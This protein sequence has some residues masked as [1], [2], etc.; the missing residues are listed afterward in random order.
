MFD[1]S[2]LLDHQ[3][4]LNVN[5]ES[6]PVILKKAFEGNNV[7]YT[8]SKQ[9]IILK[10]K[11][12]LSQKKT[13][14]QRVIS[15]VVTDNL[16]EPVIGANVI[17][18]GTTVGLITDLDGRFEIKTD[19]K[20]PVLVFSF[21]G[22]KKQRVVV[23]NRKRL[24]V[25]MKT[26]A[27]AL[28]E[29]VV[30]GFGVQKKEN[31]TGSVSQVK[32]EDVLG[33]RPIVNMASVL[34]GAMPG[35]QVTGGA[36]PGASMSFN[37]RGTLSINGGAPL[38]LID[39]VVGDPSLL[40]PEDI[41]SVTVLKDAASAAMADTRSWLDL[42]KIRASWGQ[43]GNQNISS[44]QYSPSMSIYQYQNWLSDGAYPT[45]IGTPGLVSS[46]F[47]WET[48]ETLDLIYLHSLI[49]CR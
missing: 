24:D 35:L 1:N 23:G 40:N 22:M 17:I 30:V 15:G 33:D 13:Q 37:I 10:S 47:T 7:T 26:D 8:I 36:T 38:V 48:V 12:G 34:Q 28:D 6:L 45:A 44:Y 29:V 25:K 9:Q 49:A 32:M 27:Q 19:A 2:M 43:I 31:L 20:N 4:N 41:Q 42:L 46:N 39:N 3:I 11:V 21:I 16:G 18:E 14:H 5:Q